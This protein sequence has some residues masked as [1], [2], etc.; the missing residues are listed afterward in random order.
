MAKNCSVRSFAYSHRRGLSLLWLL[1]AIAVAGAG[2]A[3]VAIPWSRNGDA[4]EPDAV[5]Y[6]VNRVLFE[7]SVVE[8]GE[9]ESSRNVEIRCEIQSRNSTG[10][11]ILEIVP[12]GTIVKPGDVLIKFDGSALENERTA[13]QSITS[14]SEALVIQSENTYETAVIG[15]KEYLEGTFAQEEQFDRER[16]LRRRGKPAPRR[17]IRALQR[18]AGRSRVCD[19]AAARGRQICRR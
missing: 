2:I 10:T 17:G 18:E 14:S 6:P 5:I 13:Q 4:V 16:S 7:H 12:A 11:M 19:G 3:A 1:G 15:R 8:P 9:I